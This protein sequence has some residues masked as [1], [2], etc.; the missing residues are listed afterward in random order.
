VAIL[1]PRRIGWMLSDQAA[2]DLRAKLSL[3]ITRLAEI[4]TAGSESPADASSP[5]LSF[6]RELEFAAT[7]PGPGGT[8]WVRQK[9]TGVVVA[10][11]DFADGSVA[12]NQELAAAGS[13]LP[14]GCIRDAVQLL[15]TYGGELTFTEGNKT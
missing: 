5:G 9:E 8:V 14:P 11:C 2:P 4:G 6:I 10:Q 15:L 3:A 13:P 7:H 1:V 12:L